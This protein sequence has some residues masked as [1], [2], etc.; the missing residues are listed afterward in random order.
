MVLADVRKLEVLRLNWVETV[1]V[2][3]GAAFFYAVAVVIKG[4]APGKIW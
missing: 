3:V 2:P 1:S 4:G